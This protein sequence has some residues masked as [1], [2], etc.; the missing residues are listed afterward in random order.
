[1]SRWWDWG[2]PLVNRWEALPAW[3]QLLTFPLL[4]PP[5]C[6]YALVKL[7]VFLCLLPFA[8][9][10]GW[11]RR[12][13]RPAGEITVAELRERADELASYFRELLE[14]NPPE[15]AE[16]LKCGVVFSRQLARLLHRPRLQPAQARHHARRTLRRVQ[17]WKGIPYFVLQKL[18]ADVVRWSEHQEPPDPAVGQRGPC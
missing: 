1:M 16:V 18:A 10:F 13:E 2:E 3:A 9:L 6:A 15:A 8:L 4:A 5:M 7:C 17:N 12:P 14:Q 11:G